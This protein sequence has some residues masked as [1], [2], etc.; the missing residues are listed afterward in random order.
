[1]KKLFAVFALTLAFVMVVPSNEAVSATCSYETYETLN[2]FG[3]TIIYNRATVYYECPD[4]PKKQ[5]L[6]SLYTEFV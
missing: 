2:I 5:G 6:P 1:M 3:Y 4:N